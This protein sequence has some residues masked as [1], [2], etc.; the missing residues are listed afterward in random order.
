MLNT[1]P[2]ILKKFI[3]KENMDEYIQ[4][5]EKNRMNM[6]QKYTRNELSYFFHVKNLKENQ[7]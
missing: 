6:K 2:A 4:M 1:H 7:I 3:S 5:H